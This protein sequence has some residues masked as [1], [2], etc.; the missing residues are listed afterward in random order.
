MNQ[1]IKTMF[2]PQ[3][4]AQ[5]AGPG[6]KRMKIDI[7]RLERYGSFVGQ[8][9]LLDAAMKEIHGTVMGPDGLDNYAIRM[10]SSYAICHSLRRWYTSSYKYLF[11]LVSASPDPRQ[12]NTELSEMVMGVTDDGWWERITLMSHF[13]QGSTRGH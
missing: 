12:V 11:P 13:I 10:Y 8:R 6:K 3:V 7:K 4:V 5:L 2:D 9:D 1:I